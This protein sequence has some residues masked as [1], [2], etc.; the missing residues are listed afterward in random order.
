VCRGTT[1]GW[2]VL[3]TLALG[4]VLAVVPGGGGVSAL[5]TEEG[6]RIAA[7]SPEPCISG[8]GLIGL[9]RF[10]GGLVFKAHRLLGSTTTVHEAYSR[11]HAAG[12]AHASPNA[13]PTSP[14]RYLEEGR[15]KA[16]WKSEFKLPWR[17][18]GPFNHHDDR[19]DLDQ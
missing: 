8:H 18:A 12:H 14:I 7:H 3:E 6:I 5:Q 2:L 17:E 19:V 15:C 16:T 9:K 11:S 4:M 1:L 10:R 13:L